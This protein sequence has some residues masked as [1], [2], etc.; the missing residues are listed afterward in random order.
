MGRAVPE[1]LAVQGFWAKTIVPDGAAIEFRTGRDITVLSLGVPTGGNAAKEGVC[2]VYFVK[3]DSH[4]LVMVSEKE[5]NKMEG[6]LGTG[7]DEQTA[8]NHALTLR[9]G[10]KKAARVK[11]WGAFKTVE[12]CFGF[13]FEVCNKK[14]EFPYEWQLQQTRNTYYMYPNRCWYNDLHV[15]P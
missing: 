6:T 1:P 11:G 7:R 8:T 15:L 10:M 14:G 12:A 3:D 13:W 9:Y 2:C 5:L 4:F